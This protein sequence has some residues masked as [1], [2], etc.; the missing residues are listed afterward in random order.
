MTTT[1]V[2]S[3]R[4]QWTTLTSGGSV[5]VGDELSPCRCGGTQVEVCAAGEWVIVCSTDLV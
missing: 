3:P 2:L 1:A 5:E 4:C